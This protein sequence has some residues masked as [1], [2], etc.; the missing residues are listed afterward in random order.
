MVYGDYHEWDAFN[1][2]FFFKRTSKNEALT[3]GQN[4]INDDVVSS[5]HAFSGI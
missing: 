3:P 1:L 4:N 5:H 2:P